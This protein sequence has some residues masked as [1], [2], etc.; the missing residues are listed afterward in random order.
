M[1]KVFYLPSCETCRKILK[2][3]P[4]NNLVLRD[5]KKEPV[6]PHELAEMHR[7]AG[8]YEALFSRRS[9]LYKSRNLKEQTLGEQDFRNLILEHYTFLNRPV[10]MIGDKIFVGSSAKSVQGAIAAL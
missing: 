1:D 6:T 2:S 3:L 8:S 9:Q 7:R 10:F 5:I 4:E